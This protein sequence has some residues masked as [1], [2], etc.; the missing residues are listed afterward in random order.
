M[1]ANPKERRLRFMRF[2]LTVLV[3]VSFAV[4]FGVLYVSLAP[5]G[6][7]DVIVTWTAILTLVSIVVAVLIY[8]G[9][10]AYVERGA[11]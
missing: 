5:V 10:K 2:G 8:Y 1:A 6:A 4:S 11:S 9:Y 3:G 7:L